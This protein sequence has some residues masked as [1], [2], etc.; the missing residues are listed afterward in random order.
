VTVVI[1]AVLLALILL[2][3]QPFFD[4]LDGDGWA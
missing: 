4:R 3:L 2:A 1:L